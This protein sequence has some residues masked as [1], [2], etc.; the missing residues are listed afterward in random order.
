MVL[1]WNY[2]S[3]IKEKET[4]VGPGKAHYMGCVESGDAENS[5]SPGVRQTE[6]TQM[7]V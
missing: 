6:G 4:G 5:E 2:I 3:C 1:K 7:E